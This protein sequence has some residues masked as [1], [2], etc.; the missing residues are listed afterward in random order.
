M[1]LFSIESKGIIKKKNKKKVKSLST[2]IEVTNSAETA[3]TAA[4]AP[5]SLKNKKLKKNNKKK[6]NSP[7]PGLP[8]NIKELQIKN[9]SVNSQRLPGN[10]HTLIDTSLN[11]A[12]TKIKMA[13]KKNQVNLQASAWKTGADVQSA[14]D[15]VKK[16]KKG[17]KC[18]KAKGE[19]STTTESNEEKEKRTIF[20]GNVSTKTTRKSLSRFFSKYGKVL[21]LAAV[22]EFVE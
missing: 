17:A 2:S 21:G 5:S 13:Q 16:N 15:A 9:G 7:K 4:A 11:G 19:L 12:S 22:N 3:S 1:F 10:T 6:K 14:T 20:V 18:R 8:S